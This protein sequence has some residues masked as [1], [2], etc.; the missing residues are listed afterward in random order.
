LDT[1]IYGISHVRGKITIEFVP[2]QTAAVLDLVLTACSNA[3][4]V[5]YHGI[6]Q[7][8][9]TSVANLC[10]RKRLCID[11]N[12]VSAGPARAGD[13]IFPTFEYMTTSLKNPVADKV[14]RRIATRNYYKN[15]DLATHIAEEHAAALTAAGMDRDANPQLAQANR[16]YW[17]KLRQPLEQRRLFPER[18]ALRTNPGTL[19]IF[20]RLSD[21]D[22]PQQLPA[23]PEPVAESEASVRLHES[24]LNTA[25]ARL[26]AG[27]TLT[28][29]SAAKKLSDLLGVDIKFAAMKDN[30]MGQWSITFTEQRP[31]VFQFDDDSVRITFRGTK[32]LVEGEEYDAMNITLT[33]RLEKIAR[34]VRVKAAE[35]VEV[36]APGKER[37]SRKQLRF[38][39]VLNNHLKELLQEPADID[40]IPLPPSLGKDIRLIPIQGQTAR[41]WLV[42]GIRRGQ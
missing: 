12:G 17:E 16:D 2:C 31:I 38:K 27:K 22:V 4:S 10:A 8:H 30:E 26:F 21:A 1:D 42:V 13:Q 3:R 37:L 41:G 33:F 5:G 6:A 36:S 25:A 29:A 40:Q 34:G 32:F 24:V 39:A 7:S 20:F 15:Q 19:F 28:P 18:V 9:N 14:M 35:E 11:A 23:A